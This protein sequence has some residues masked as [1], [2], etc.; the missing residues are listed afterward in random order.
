VCLSSNEAEKFIPSKKGNGYE[1]TPEASQE[2]DEKNEEEIDKASS[3]GTTIA[4]DAIFDGDKEGAFYKLLSSRMAKKVT[5]D[6]SAEEDKI[7]KKSPTETE[8]E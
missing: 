3:P 8:K 4:L 6:V 5:F 7:F 1:L 2:S